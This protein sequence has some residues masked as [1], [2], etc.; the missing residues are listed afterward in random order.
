LPFLREKKEEEEKRSEVKFIS[1]C[2]ETG[3]SER[4]RDSEADGISIYE[5]KE[6]GY[7]FSMK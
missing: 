2:S 1:L 7:V 4:E 3:G 6:F 5:E